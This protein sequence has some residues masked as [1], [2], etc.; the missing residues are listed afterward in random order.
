ML[1]EAQVLGVLRFATTT[2]GVQFV[3]TCG[4]MWMLKWPADNWVLALKVKYQCKRILIMS[5]QYDMFCDTSNLE[6]NAICTCLDFAG[7]FGW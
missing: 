6:I 4:I 3:M 5:I 1:E 2:S 7:L